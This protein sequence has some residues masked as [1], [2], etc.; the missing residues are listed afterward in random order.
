MTGG[1][2]IDVDGVDAQLGAKLFVSVV[3]ICG[4]MQVIVGNC[5]V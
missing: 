2:A 1:T 3:L 5:V 4:E